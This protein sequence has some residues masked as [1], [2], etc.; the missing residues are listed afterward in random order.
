MGS[1]PRW[2]AYTRYDL[3]LSTTLNYLTTPHQYRLAYHYIPGNE[4]TVVFCHGYGSNMQ[5]DKAVAMENAC[6]TWG[7]SYLRFDLSGCGASEGDFASATMT[8][9]LD[10]ALY[11]IDQ[12]TTGPIILVGSSMGAW[13]MVLIAQA[14]PERVVR[15]L[16]IASA[17]DMTDYKLAHGLNEAQ[18]QRLKS[19]GVIGLHNPDFETPLPLYLT[20][21]ISGAL[22]RVLETPINLPI[23]LTL[24][25]ARDDQDVPWRRSQAL[26]TLWMGAKCE[27][28][29]LPRGGHRLSDESSLA[30]L[31]DALQKLVQ[32]TL[33]SKNAS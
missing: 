13:L 31:I 24:I 29:L 5:G 17:P 19:E 16:G 27:L 11:L 7:Q 20:L 22:H 28:I 33:P 3:V 8:R 30:V 32:Q 12:I 21:L 25:H 4:P 15:C 14:R 2:V 18:Q 1:T 9:W 26:Q 23:P 10:D 6:L